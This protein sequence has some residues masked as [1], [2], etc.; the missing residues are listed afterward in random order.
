MTSKKSKLDSSDPNKT[1]NSGD[2]EKDVIPDPP[3]YNTENY[4]CLRGKDDGSMYYGEIGYMK[5]ETGQVIKYGS[6]AYTAQIKSMNE[7]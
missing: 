3:G 2:A 7:E 5:K 4:K 1:A 6:E